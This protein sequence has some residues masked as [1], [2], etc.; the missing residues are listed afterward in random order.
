MKEQPF[1]ERRQSSHGH[2]PCRHLSCSG[3]RPHLSSKRTDIPC[4]EHFLTGRLWGGQGWPAAGLALSKAKGPVQVAGAPWTSEPAG[5]PGPKFAGP[6]IK[7]QI[8]AP[9]FL[10]YI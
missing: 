1:G 4:V 6:G 2:C 3:H 8:E 5:R 9:I 7:I 10:S